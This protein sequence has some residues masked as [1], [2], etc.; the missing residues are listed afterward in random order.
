MR[1]SLFAVTVAGMATLG[2]CASPS[3]AQDDT[4]QKLGT[5]HFATSCNDVIGSGKLTRPAP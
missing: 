1:K 2:F 5:V 4:D 3:L